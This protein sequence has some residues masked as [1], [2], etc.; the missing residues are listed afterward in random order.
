VSVRDCAVR[1][2]ARFH[3]LADARQLAREALRDAALGYDP[4]S[5][6]REAREALTVAVLVRDYIEADSGRRSSATN[7]DYRRTLKAVVERSPIGQQAAAQVARGELRAFLEGTARKTPIR[8]NRVRQPKPCPL[9]DE[10]NI[11]SRQVVE[12]TSKALPSDT[13]QQKDPEAP[14]VLREGLVESSRADMEHRIERD[15]QIVVRMAHRRTAD[16]REVAS[17]ELDHCLDPS[18]SD[19]CVLAALVSSTPTAIHQPQSGFD[20]G[21]LLSRQ[22]KKVLRRPEPP[23]PP[24]EPLFLRPMHPCHPSRRLR[25]SFAPALC[26]ATFAYITTVPVRVRG[27]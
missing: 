18:A 2:S 20:V 23:T 27:Y 5:A 11:A 6:K 22:A 3:R 26:A 14:K 21:G 16:G 17:H 4:A 7:G 19:S 13:F 12:R 15:P 24:F 10:S 1:R 8:A 25:R 9:R